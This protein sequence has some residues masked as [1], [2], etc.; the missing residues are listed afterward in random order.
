M[1]QLVRIHPDN[2]Q[3]RL[4]KQAAEIIRKGGIAAYPTDSAYALGCHIGNKK[5]QDKICAIRKIDKNHKFTLMCADLSDISL[6]AKMDNK[7][8]K[9]LKNLTPGPY[10]F[11]FAATRDVPRRLQNPKR[12]TIGI[13]VPDNNIVQELLAELGEPIMSVSLIM[14]GNTTALNNPDEIYAKLKDKADIIVAG[15]DCANQPT[16]VVHF[17]SGVPEVTRFGQG[18]P[19]RLSL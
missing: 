6:Y 13:R 5:A 19:A 4:I 8:F 7:A 17:E 11:I 12:K 10:T 15:G 1:S 14:P 2:P 3:L 9:I 18:D 16:T